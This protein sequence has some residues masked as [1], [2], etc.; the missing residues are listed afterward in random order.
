MA[1]GTA[2]F[3]GRALRA[4]RQTR[5]VDGELLSAQALAER[6]GTSKS[7]V[8]A[9]ENNTSTPD[10]K[11]IAEIIRLFGIDE[12]R[13]LRRNRVLA[14]IHGLR[15]QRGLTM[16]EA[17]AQVGISRSG[18]AN[19]ERHALLPVRDDGTVRM[20]LARVFGVAPAVIDRALLRHPEAVA[21]QTQLARQLGIVFERAHQEHTPAVIDVDD[22]LLLRIAPLVQR[23]T[24]V[25]CR[26]VN[27]ELDAYRDLLRD[28]ARMKVDAA[29]AQS[30]ADAALAHKRRSRLETLIKEA[31]PVASKNLSRFLSEAMNVRQWRLM[32]ALANAGLDGIALPSTTR[33]ASVEDLT[34]L[35]IR[36]YATVLQRGDQTYATPTEGGI[37]TVRTN[38]AR[39]GR[40]YPRVPAPNLSRYW[41]QRRRPRPL[42]R[43]PGQQA[44]EVS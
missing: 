13:K 18:Y 3:D 37:A 8:L 41:E 6:L 42:V 32:V 16:A 10:P 33:Y 27:A 36:Q 9:Y 14:D 28:H 44:P 20:N 40:L 30:T 17:A 22:P 15:C 7:R 2:D 5:P 31:A 11:R 24:R 39:Y 26:L 35:Q 43:R 34:V 4:T 21:R 38:Y 25:A 29:F 12:P 23:P 19:L 1:R